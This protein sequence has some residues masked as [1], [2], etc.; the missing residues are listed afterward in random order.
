MKFFSF[1]VL[2]F[3][4]F[5]IQGNAVFAFDIPEFPESYVNDY[6]DLFSREESSLLEATIQDLRRNGGIETG[7]VTV[8]SLDG[9]R[10][11][12]L[13]RR[14]LN[15]WNIGAGAE[16]KGMLLLLSGLEKEMHIAVTDELLDTIT[17]ARALWIMEQRMS[18]AFKNGDYALGFE[19]A[20]EAVY[21]GVVLGVFPWEQM[22]A[23]VVSEGEV[24]Y[25]PIVLGVIFV[26][27]LLMFLRRVRRV[28]G[29]SNTL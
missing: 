10:I 12:S 18:P 3:C 27:C 17:S 5:C 21:S 4:V 7:V 16:G 13:S 25:A 22:K 20:I 23:Q 15:T 29:E 14:I 2:F 24:S 1:A 9:E 26:L 19:L 28:A 6:A 8:V 11:E